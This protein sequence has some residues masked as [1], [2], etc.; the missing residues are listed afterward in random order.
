[1]FSFVFFSN[2]FFLKKKWLMHYGKECEIRGEKGLSSCVQNKKQK[3]KGKHKNLN[4]SRNKEGM[5]FP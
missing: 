2:K 1:M 4:L 3:T 5:R